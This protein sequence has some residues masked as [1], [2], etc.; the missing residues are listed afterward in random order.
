MTT[1]EMQQM[2]D[3]L[4]TLSDYM[5]TLLCDNP[6]EVAELAANELVVRRVKNRR[7]ELDGIY[8]R[9]S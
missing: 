8:R 5:V 7:E 9:Y 4:A 2:G 1:R 3:F 6:K